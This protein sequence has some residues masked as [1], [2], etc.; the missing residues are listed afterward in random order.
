MSKLTF[1]DLQ[2]NGLDLTQLEA[3]ALHSPIVQIAQ[4]GNEGLNEVIA[5]APVEEAEE[6]VPV[7]KETAKEKKAREAA[8]AEA[9][10]NQDG[11]EEEK[12]ADPAA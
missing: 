6:E 4:H 11:N 2:K 10:K 7:K 8:E 1:A 9:A 3:Q 5:P 12:P